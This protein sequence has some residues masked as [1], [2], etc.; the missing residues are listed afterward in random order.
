MPTVTSTGFAKH[1]VALTADAETIVELARDCGTVEVVN[2]ESTAPVYVTVDGS[3]ATVGG[4][5]A[6]VLFAGPNVLR[7]RVPGSVG[8]TKVR[9]ISAADAT[10]SVSGT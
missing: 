9:L 8:L 7:L 2:W 10:I 5:S 3:A 6:Y 4:D 1:N